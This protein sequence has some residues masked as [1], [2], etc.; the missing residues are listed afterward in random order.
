[1]VAEFTQQDVDG[2]SA[3]I[4]PEREDILEG[5][6]KIGTLVSFV[7]EPPKE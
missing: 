7:P 2:L 3:L 4:G 1:M 5:R 6:G